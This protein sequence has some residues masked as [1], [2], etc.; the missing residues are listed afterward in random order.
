M[1]M[2]AIQRSSFGS[3]LP[4]STLP[5]SASHG[6]IERI[7]AHVDEL[8]QG[9]EQPTLP[10]WEAFQTTLDQKM[11]SWGTALEGSFS[12]LRMLQVA[13]QRAAQTALTK[14]ETQ[15]QRRIVLLRDR[16]EARAAEVKQSY[17]LVAQ[18]RDE[19]KNAIAESLKAL[20]QEVDQRIESGRL[21]M[22]T[23]RQDLDEC[24][25]ELDALTT[26]VHAFATEKDQAARRWAE[27]ERSEWQQLRQN[28]GKIQTKLEQLQRDQDHFETEIQHA[29]EEV[30]QLHQSIQQT[31]EELR[32]KLEEQRQLVTFIGIGIALLCVPALLASAAGSGMA[33]TVGVA[34]GEEFSVGITYVFG[35]GF[36]AHLGPLV[37]AGGCAGAAAA[38]G[39]GGG[40]GRSGSGQL[41]STNGTGSGASV[42]T[43]GSS[44]TQRP[45]PPKRS[46][47]PAFATE[48]AGIVQGG[49]HRPSSTFD[50]VSS[51]A[52]TQKQLPQSPCSVQISQSSGQQRALREQIEQTVQQQ[53]L[54]SLF[55]NNQYKGIEETLQTFVRYPAA[56]ELVN[57]VTR[58]G[59]IA[60]RRGFLSGSVN[61]PKRVI[62]LPQADV[63]GVGLP[64]VVGSALL[65]ELINLSN[66][67]HLEPLFARMCQMNANDYA[68]EIERFEHRTVQQHHKTAS[69]CIQ[70][71]FWPS[72][73]DTKKNLAESCEYDLQ[74][75][76]AEGHTENY[77][78]Q[79]RAYCGASPLV[80]D[81]E[82]KQMHETHRTKR[83]MV[84]LS[85]KYLKRRPFIATLMEMRDH[86]PRL[87]IAPVEEQDHSSEQ[88]REWVEETVEGFAIDQFTH[89]TRTQ[90]IAPLVDLGARVLHSRFQST[91]NPIRDRILSG[92]AHLTA[93]AALTAFLPESL[94]GYVAIAGAHGLEL[95][96]DK[97]ESAALSL[98]Q[99]PESARIKE[100]CL[101]A[102]QECETPADLGEEVLGLVPVLKAP[103]QILQKAHDKIM[104][105]A[106]PTFDAIGL[107]DANAAKFFKELEKSAELAV[108]LYP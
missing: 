81:T 62:S 87:E 94:P 11:R 51:L 34:A 65:F 69:Q 21:A 39:G 46:V 60:I 61:I 84:R 16:M 30:V 18:N 1:T 54:Q 64:A 19:V 91:D 107:T 52:Q 79:W 73:W 7:R 76:E 68:L 36:S 50:A 75:Q 102:N 43:T 48:V 14:L 58:K 25:G 8:E 17:E 83:D 13:E 27:Q 42:L 92:A 47:D 82:Q 37:L 101:A 77:R 41:P 40:S 63:M 44:S 49:W 45:Q 95:L 100:L 35:E 66:S 5:L 31:I 29:Q 10:E 78:S 56:A 15:D 23:M 89:R 90:R 26:R 103:A 55:H 70:Q 2:H 80:S 99:D 28:I 74:R 106:I 85:R 38:I 98:I 33:T 67:P 3:L 86:V 53:A 9:T 59:P 24:R 32:E 88:L 6:D 12:S 104:D 93:E 108:Q 72:S 96:A 22:T 71:G 97:I 20:E 57:E 105:L 4:Y